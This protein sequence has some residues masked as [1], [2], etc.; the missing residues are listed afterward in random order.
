M[1][2]I[3]GGYTAT[4]NALALGQTADGFRV[5]HSEF[6]RIITGDSFG[7]TPQDGVRRG[8]E[9]FV[10]LRGLEYNAAGMQNAF[11]P[12]HATLYTLGVIGRLDVGSSIVDSLV[13]TAIAGTTAAT[14]PATATFTQCILAEGFPVELLFAA[15]LREVPLRLRVYPVA[16]VFGTQT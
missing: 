11:W 13:L 16:G 5:S 3:A 14:V 10:A 7:E 6:K 2:F 1:S 12:G 9:M 15:D 4:L 8:A